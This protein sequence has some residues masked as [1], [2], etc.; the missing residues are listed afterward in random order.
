[1]CIESHLLDITDVIIKEKEHIISQNGR[2]LAVILDY[3]VENIHRMTFIPFEKT[4]II[5]DVNVYWIC[6]VINECLIKIL[7][8]I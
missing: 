6:N 5:T 3:V 8:K 7:M 4:D 2:F 1:M